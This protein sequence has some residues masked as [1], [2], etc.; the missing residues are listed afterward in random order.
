[1]A[2]RRRLRRRRQPAQAPLLEHRGQHAR[3]LAP[4]VPRLRLRR[5]CRHARRQ[6]DGRPWK[7][8][9][10][11]SRAGPA[12]SW[13][14]ALLWLRLRLTLRTTQALPL[15]MRASPDVRRRLSR[16]DHRPNLPTARRTAGTPHRPLLCRFH[17]EPPICRPPPEH[18]RGA[19]HA[20]PAK[21]LLPS[22]S[23][24]SEPIRARVHGCSARAGPLV[25]STRGARAV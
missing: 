19:N 4:M 8:A 9:T 12:A 10:C 24:H 23:R 25:F 22:P 14:S 3:R 1:M 17:G 13:S 7:T 6:L 5:C 11:A 20:R 2:A 18:T 16:R 21:P 15:A